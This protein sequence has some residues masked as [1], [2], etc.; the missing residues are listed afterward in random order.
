MGTNKEL[1]AVYEK[2]QNVKSLIDDA[3]RIEGLVRHA[4]M[5][6]AGVV[7]SKE[8]LTDS[9]PVQIVND[10]QIVTQYPMEDL[11]RYRLLKMDFLGLRN[12]TMIANA[13]D[14]ISIRREST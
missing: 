11:A 8:P 9:V 2:D 13:R 3:K 5:H 12:L 4:S 6:A 10:T 7:I 1:N 14:N